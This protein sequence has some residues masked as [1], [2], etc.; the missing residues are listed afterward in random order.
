MDKKGTKIK[1]TTEAKDNREVEYRFTLNFYVYEDRGLFAAYCP[2]LDL[3]TADTSFDG[4]ITS[5]YEIFQLYVEECVEHN[6]LIADMKAHGW[7]VKKHELE[8]PSFYN[9]MKKPQLKQLMNSQHDFER[10]SHRTRARILA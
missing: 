4:A 1:L 9:L 7:K 2:S 10:I 3:L 8:E 5:F 6:T